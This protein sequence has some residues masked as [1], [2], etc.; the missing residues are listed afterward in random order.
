MKKRVLL[1]LLLNLFCCKIYSQ[2]WFSLDS[3]LIGN[4][5]FDHVNAFCADTVH[6]ILWAGGSFQTTFNGDSLNSLGYWNGIQWLPFVNIVNGDT[7]LGFKDG[8]INDLIIYDGKLVIAK[9][10]F[11]N[12][13]SFYNVVSVNSDNNNVMGLGKFNGSIHT[14]CIYHDTLYAGGE[15]TTYTNFYFPFNSN[16]VSRIATWNGTDFTPVGSGIGVGGIVYDLCVYNDKLIA[17]GYFEGAG[18]N[19]CKNIAAWDGTAWSAIGN[20]IGQAG[21]YDVIVHSAESY[22]NKLF[23]G[24]DFDLSSTQVGQGLIYWDG[25]NWNN[26]GGDFGDVRTIKVFNDKLYAGPCNFILP[27]NEISYYDDSVWHS[28]GYGPSDDVLA[29]EDYSGSI[30][31]GGKF[32]NIQNPLIYT[33]YVA[34]FE[35]AIDTTGIEIN[36]SNENEISVYPNPSNETIFIHYNLQNNSIVTISVFDLYGT[37]KIKKEISTQQSGTQTEIVSLKELPQGIYFIRVLS[38]EFSNSVKIV[39]K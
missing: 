13:N 15:F 37:E 25:I 5:Q 20:G 29:I 39:K 35:P 1:F 38:N 31:A 26:A 6:N 8:I 9:E 21:T 16:N 33:G 12:G 36:E 28:M 18:G 17:A 10:W 4:G 14:L 7:F 2:Q 3:G 32:L 22:H 27:V 23:V 34:R 19:Y 11:P 24:G 30:Y